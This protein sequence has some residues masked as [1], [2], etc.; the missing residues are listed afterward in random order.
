VALHA[1][2]FDDLMNARSDADQGAHRHSR[3]VPNNPFEAIRKTVG[4]RNL[5]AATWPPWRK[6]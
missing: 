2:R 6:V 1:V 4:R 5:A 3:C